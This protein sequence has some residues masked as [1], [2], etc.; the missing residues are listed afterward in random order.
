MHKDGKT[1]AEKKISQ[2][3]L[4]L[5]LQFDGLTCK[6]ISLSLKSAI[7]INQITNHIRPYINT[8]VH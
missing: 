7:V 4:T 3:G 1:L 6:V 5:I 8:I 2:L